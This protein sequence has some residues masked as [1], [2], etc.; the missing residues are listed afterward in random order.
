ME[1]K[2]LVDLQTR[3]LKMFK[4][5]HEFCVSHNLCYYAIDGTFLGAVRH[6][7]FIPWDDDIDVGMPRKDYDR[8]IELFHS[9][10]IDGYDLGSPLSKGFQ[11]RYPYCKLYDAN[12]TLVENTWPPLRR[13][14][15]IDVF[16]LDGLGNTQEESTQNWRRIKNKLNLIWMRVCAPRK[17]R[18]FIK[19]CAIVVAHIIP[20]NCTIDK[21]LLQKIDY[22]CRQ[23]DFDKAKIGGNV[24]SDWGLKEIMPVQIMGTPTLYRFGDILVYGPEKA[25]AYLTHLYGN[26][27][28]LPPKE[29]QISHHDYLVLDMDSPYLV[30]NETKR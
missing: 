10:T 8:L 28:S 15:F 30:K 19:N 23:Y 24:F 13:G 27:R 25:D 3:L 20:A 4:W 16:P 17:S 6:Q 22:E 29:K 12:T 1:N 7:G 9:T 26:W 11:Y 21:L 5:F 18:S 2:Q 14:I